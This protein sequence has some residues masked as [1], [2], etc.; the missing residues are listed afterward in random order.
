MGVGNLRG[1]L[2][3]AQR[4]AEMEN[5]PNLARK[6]MQAGDES[7]A[8]RTEPRGIES[9]RVGRRRLSVHAA[10]ALVQAADAM[11]V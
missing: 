4:L 3:V 8:A 10:G 2:A 1:E 5:D 7:T 9:G 11:S 6:L